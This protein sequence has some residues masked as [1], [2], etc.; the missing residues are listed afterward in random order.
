M[1][2]RAVPLVIVPTYQQAFCSNA[3]FGNTLVM[4][5]KHVRPIDRVIWLL[6]T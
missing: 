4:S 6:F 3:T 1:E 2:Q 5:C